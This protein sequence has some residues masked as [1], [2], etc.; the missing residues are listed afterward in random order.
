[1]LHEFMYSPVFKHEAEHEHDEA[2]R[3]KDEHGINVVLAEAFGQ[4]SKDEHGHAVDWP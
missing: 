1:M 3:A 2:K 4:P